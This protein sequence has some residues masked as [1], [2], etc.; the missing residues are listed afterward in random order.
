MYSCH[1]Q[2]NKSSTETVEESSSK[3]AAGNCDKEKNT[4]PP[5]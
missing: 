2:K 4:F 1:S 3:T 5:R